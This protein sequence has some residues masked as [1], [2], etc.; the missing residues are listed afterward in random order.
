MWVGDDEVVDVGVG[1]EGCVEEGGFLVGEML[2]GE[3]GGVGVLG[4]L[5]GEEE[6]VGDD[7]VGDP[8]GEDGHG[9]VEGVGGGEGGPVEDCCGW[10]RGVSRGVY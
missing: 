4:V 9:V 6:E 10:G 3:V 7:A 5:V 2:E 1:G 8:D